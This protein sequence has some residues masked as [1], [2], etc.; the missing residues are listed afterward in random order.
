[1]GYF[2]YNDE[3]FFDAKK[4]YERALIR[5]N[6]LTGKVNPMKQVR[7]CYM[8]GSC[9]YYLDEYESAHRDYENCLLI[10]HRVPQNKVKQLLTYN[11]EGNLGLAKMKLGIK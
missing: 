6:Q 9:S 7:A 1:M 11:I 10:L 2:Y 4:Y 8:K 5:L 3:S